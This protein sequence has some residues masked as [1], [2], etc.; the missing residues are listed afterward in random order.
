MS[1]SV[2]LQS[3]QGYLTPKDKHIS[4]RNNKGI[5]S[6]FS[7]GHGSIPQAANDFQVSTMARPLYEGSVKDSPA[8]AAL[9]ARGCHYGHR[10]KLLHRLMTKHMQK[11]SLQRKHKFLR[12]NTLLAYQ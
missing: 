8:L 9:D 2:S 12:G 1:Q 10:E 6:E 4:I 11:T 5:Y 7:G 3:P